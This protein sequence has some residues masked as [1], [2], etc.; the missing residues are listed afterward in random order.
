MTHRAVPFTSGEPP[1]AAVCAR[2]STS[3]AGAAAETVIR[4]PLMVAMPASA[5]VRS[6]TELNTMCVAL[7][8]A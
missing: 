2:R 6:A 5:A 8:A 7:V 3:A 1:R 4:S